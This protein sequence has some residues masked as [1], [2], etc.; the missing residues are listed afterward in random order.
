MSDSAVWRI[1]GEDDDE[2]AENLNSSIEDLLNHHPQSEAT[3]DF[4]L[5]SSQTKNCCFLPLLRPPKV[6]LRISSEPAFTAIHDRDNSDND[7]NGH[8]D[9]ASTT[10]IDCFLADEQHH[11]NDSDD[12]QETATSASFL[13]WDQEQ[14]EEYHPCQPFVP[15][16]S[17]SSLLRRSS[18]PPSQ[19]NNWTGFQHFFS[20]SLQKK[21]T[22]TPSTNAEHNEEGCI[23]T[24]VAEPNCSA[25]LLFPD[26]EALR[27]WSHLSR[28]FEQEYNN[29][30]FLDEPQPQDHDLTMTNTTA[31]AL[32]PPTTNRRRDAGSNNDNSHEQNGDD[33]FWQDPS[34]EF[35]GVLWKRRDV[36]KLRWRPRFFVLRPRQ[37]VLQYYLFQNH[38]T[39]TT[40]A[41]SQQ[42]SAQ[43]DNVE[44]QRQPMRAEPQTPQQYQ[45][46]TEFSES[47][48]ADPTRTRTISYDTWHSNI[49]DITT[50]P[51]LTL[52]TTNTSTP[53]SGAAAA[54]SNAANNNPNNIAAATH[55][56]PQPPPWQLDTTGL[57]PRGTLYLP[58][59]TV[60]AN[61]ALTV[62]AESLYALTI[63]PPTSG[64]A[65]STH[66]GGTTTTTLSRAAAVH[67]AA[68]TAGQRDLWIR[69][70]QRVCQRATVANRVEEE[71]I[72][73]GADDGLPETTHPSFQQDDDATIPPH[74]TPRRGESD[75]AAVEEE[76]DNPLVTNE[77]TTA[78]RSSYHNRSFSSPPALNTPPRVN[79]AVDTDAP[80]N[81][82]LNDSGEEEDLWETLVQPN[83]DDEIALFSD[84]PAGLKDLIQDKI[85]QY[86][87]TLLSSV[88]DKKDG[89][90][91]LQQLTQPDSIPAS[92]NDNAQWAV[93][94]LHAY[95]RQER[96]D[97]KSVTMVH[98][99]AELSVPEA[100]NSHSS[101]NSALTVAAQILSILVDHEHRPKYEATCAGSKRLR[102]YN[103]HTSLD[104]YHYD[105]SPLF[106]RSVACFLHWRCLRQGNERAILVVGGSCP[107]ASQ[108][109]NRAEENNANGRGT[110]AQMNKE[111]KLYISMVLVQPKPQSS[112]ILYSRIVALD[113]VVP[114]WVSNMAQPFVVQPQIKQPKEILQYL[115]RLRQSREE[116]FL[117]SAIRSISTAAAS[118]VLDEEWLTQHCL[119]TSDVMERERPTST[120]PF[121]VASSEEG[122]KLDLEEESDALPSRT[123]IVEAPSFVWQASCLFA[124][125]IL[126][127]ALKI[128]SG[129]LN[130][131]LLSMAPNFPFFM[132]LVAAWWSLRHWV[133]AHYKISPTNL[134]NRSTIPPVI[135]SM[136]CRFPVQVKGALRYI[137]N[138]K[139]EQ[140]LRSSP[141]GSLAPE[142]DA[143]GSSVDFKEGMMASVSM[144]HIV[145]SA[146]A[147][148]WSKH[149]ESQSNSRL[150][151]LCVPW[152][153]IDERYIVNPDK[154]SVH[155]AIVA[156]GPRE[157]NT[158]IIQQANALSVQD[159]ADRQ[160]IAKQSSSLAAHNHMEPDCAVVLSLNNYSTTPT[161]ATSTA[162]EWNA[163]PQGSTQ[164]VVTIGGLEWEQPPEVESTRRSKAGKDSKIAERQPVLSLSLTVRHENAAWV[165]SQIVPELQTLLQFPEMCDP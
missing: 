51:H 92:S 30:L 50:T 153:A 131:S 137:S 103:P 115:Q 122:D 149:L 46:P 21:D 29:N 41:T 98:T 57:V 70:L 12:Q 32:T 19:N 104:V 164:V 69:Q 90:K 10:D 5:S 43:T 25:H 138:Q 34:Y 55:Q 11:R 8:I 117:F 67:L 112:S 54:R 124:P 106:P 59:C 141:G 147:K 62:V 109:W 111:S 85:R 72:I 18:V 121:S 93:Q 58:G 28:A 163:L 38:G 49:S 17:T 14:D 16:E 126:Y 26:L 35:T 74:N 100:E 9:I 134:K 91:C 31:N 154:N 101:G 99:T 89:W 20:R 87:P 86:Q 88:H 81:L 108:A 76:E 152:F 68:R 60:S 148:V 159:I 24:A 65:L 78:R 44:D 39:T 4:N 145:A 64:G 160:E 142:S 22:R 127:H 2:A 45:P 36:F 102:Q 71:E 1:E 95:S 37:G 155:V 161:A 3:S 61:D 116:P 83:N 52:T 143:N 113:P 132:F 56:Q 7:E 136:T 156:P 15:E 77:S 151:R 84:V 73:A 80:T 129:Y 150:C 42:P 140:L 79:V 139:E 107:Q 97:N 53:S 63:V 165:A 125:I 75:G 13:I 144:V 133:L 158:V 130:E 23:N 27:Y 6:L 120:N 135:S 119:P 157:A 162:T 128:T 146:V 94:Q 123:S 66:A 105:S 33:L 118:I 47:T 114:S 40:T 110:K 82:Q 48:D 96:P